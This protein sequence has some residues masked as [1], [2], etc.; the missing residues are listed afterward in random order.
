MEL[1]VGLGVDVIRAQG[2]GVIAKHRIQ[3]VPEHQ[4][5]IHPHSLPWSYSSIPAF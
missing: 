3:N 2:S 1:E 4:L 5:H